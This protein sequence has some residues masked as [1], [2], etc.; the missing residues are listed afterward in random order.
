MAAAGH[1]IDTL[2]ADATRTE[3]WERTVK[4]ALE[5]WGHID[6]L[7]NNLGDAIR[8]PLVPLPP[9]NPGEGTPLPA[10]GGMKGSST[11]ISD[12]EYRFVLDVNLTEAFMGCRAVGPHMLERGRGKVINISSVSAR[13][14]APETLVYSLAKAALVRL[15]QTLALEWAPYGL[16]VNCIAP[17]NFPDVDHGDP[18]QLADR[19]EWA[20]T[21]IPLGRVGEVREVGY[22]ALYLVS[23]ASNYMTG[24]TLYLDGGLSF[25]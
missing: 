11:P 23:D 22:L 9:L 24:E 17:G 19:R 25:R 20:K 8:K 21:S 12:E 2:Q 5:R 6:V 7:I 14:G 16:T 15:T 3:D 1:P 18:A 4:V 10:A 13:R